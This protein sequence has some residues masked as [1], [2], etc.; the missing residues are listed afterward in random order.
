MGR[1]EHIDDVTDSL[2]LRSG[3]NLLRNK[4]LYLDC[5]N[6]VYN[7][8]NLTT[9]KMTKRELFQVNKRTH[10]IDMPSN[11]LGVFSV[12]VMDH[13]GVIWPMFLNDSLHKDIVEVSAAKNCACENQCGYSL[14]NLIKGYESIVSTKSDTLPNGDPISFTC[15]DRKAINKE[16][17]LFIETQYPKRIY[18]DGVWTDTVLFTENKK[19]CDL[20]LDDNGCVCDTHDNECNVCNAFGIKNTDGIPFGGDANSFCGDPNINTWRYFASS[21]LQWFGVQCGSFHH[22]RDGFK[23]IYNIEEGQKKLIFP[24]DF[25]FDKVLV[26][27]YHDVD[28]SDMQIPILS[29]QTFMTGLQY[30]A[31]E[32]NEKKQGVANIF[33][34]KYS[35]QKWGLFLE[36]NKLTMD[37]MRMILTPPIYV[38]SYL[39]HRRDRFGGY[40][41]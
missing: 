31:Y 15:V 27:W 25:P 5:A 17:F 3:D 24:H 40:T 33:G 36:L 34:Q 26:R 4:G 20:E 37:E 28:L 35:R 7:D 41:Y 16:G 21:Q 38:P 6:D 8:L 2:C 14:C 10:T 39:D 30:F 23:N 29:K 11:N 1:F 18:T 12:S 9:V 19:L 22:R 13:H 32:Y